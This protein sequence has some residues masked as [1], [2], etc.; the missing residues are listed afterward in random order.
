MLIWSNRSRTVETKKCFEKEFRQ[1][2]LVDKK[3]QID[4]EVKARNCM[5]I[6]LQNDKCSRGRQMTSR[7][8]QWFIWEVNSITSKLY[9]WLRID[10]N[11]GIT[12]KHEIPFYCQIMQEED[13]AFFGLPQLY[14]WNMFFNFVYK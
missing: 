2:V 3:T 12:K 6:C 9:L 8:I 1:Y 13:S 7:R 4:R 10:G 11:K 5:I 14:Y